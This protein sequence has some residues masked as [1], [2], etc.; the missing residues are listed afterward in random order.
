MINERNSTSDPLYNF[1]ACGEKEVYQIS[2]REF[3]HIK[4]YKIDK[5]TNI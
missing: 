4:N 1:R 5:Y 2:T 3:S